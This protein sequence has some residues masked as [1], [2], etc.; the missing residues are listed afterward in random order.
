MPVTTTRPPL[1]HDTLSS[2]NMFNG[3]IVIYGGCAGGEDEV[4]DYSN[5][6]ISLTSQDDFD[7][8]LDIHESTESKHSSKDTGTSSG[9]TT[10]NDDDYGVVPVVL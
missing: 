9:S 6:F 5:K 4:A 8:D 1:M 3:N 7:E 2:A 10:S